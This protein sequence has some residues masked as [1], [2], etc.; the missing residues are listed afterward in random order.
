MCSTRVPVNLK[1]KPVTMLSKS[2]E[3]ASGGWYVFAPPD[4]MPPE[5][6][7]KRNEEV[8]WCPYCAG[9][10]IFKQRFEERDVYDCKGYCGWSN[11]KDF[12]VKMVNKLWNQSIQDAVAN[13]Y[14]QYR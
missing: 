9:W 4:E 11:T 10:M 2:G 8:L 5:F 3:V 1:R 13:R 14:R 12:H 7:T 6:K